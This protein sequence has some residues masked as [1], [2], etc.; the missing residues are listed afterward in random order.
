MAKNHCELVATLGVIRAYDLNSHYNSGE[1][2]G[3]Y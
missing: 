1:K 2:R 3:S